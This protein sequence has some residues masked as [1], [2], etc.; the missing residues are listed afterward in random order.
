MN[1][2]KYNRIHIDVGANDGKMALH[3]ARYEPKT[4][5]I[6]FEPVPVLAEKIK[7]ESSHLNNFMFHSSLEM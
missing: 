3:Y 1:W 2:S 4:F 7:E 5:V 6:A